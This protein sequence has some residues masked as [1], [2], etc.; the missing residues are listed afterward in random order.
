MDLQPNMVTFYNKYRQKKVYAPAE[1]VVAY[2]QTEAVYW[3]NNASWRQASYI[4]ALY[5][6]WRKCEP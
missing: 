2:V 4:L 6:F 3:I 1:I 5:L